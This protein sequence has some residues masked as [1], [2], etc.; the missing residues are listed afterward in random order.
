MRFFM[1]AK[2]FYTNKDLI[3][4]RFGRLYHLPV[5]LGKLGHE[6]FV[7]AADYR[8]KERVGIAEKGVEFGTEPLTVA[9]LPRFSL[10]LLR[11]A[12]RFRPD[13]ILASGDIHLGF[14]GLLLARLLG[15]ELVFDVYDNYEAFAS[16]RIPGLKS[17]FH[18]TLRRADLVVCAGEPIRRLVAQY[19]DST[20]V[21]PNGV[22]KTLFRP[23][24]QSEARSELGIPDT[25]Q[26]VGYFGAIA[27]NRGVETLVEAVRALRSSG[28]QIRL[29]LAGV[30]TVDIDRTEGWIDYRGVVSQELVAMLINGCDVAVIP[31]RRGEQIDFSAANKLS[32][33]IACSVPVVTTDVSDYGALFYGNT[34]AVCQPGDVAGMARAIGQQIDHPFRLPIERASSW[35]ELAP[36]LTRTM[37]SA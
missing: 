10:R 15:V 24:D 4:D 20:A 11:E 14:L 22:D 30:V 16:A 18:F 8:S 6:G 23:I 13:V 9:R 33:Y 29:L 25:E 31:Y 36:R 3:G 21:I 19:N 1:L 34:G 37:K 35:S 5:E 12:R 28:R 26:V 17:L 27:P 7:I 2:R 32:E